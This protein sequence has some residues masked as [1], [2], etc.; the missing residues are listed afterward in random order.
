MGDAEERLSPMPP[1][2]RFAGQ[3]MFLWMNGSKNIIH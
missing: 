3:V 2:S 1:G